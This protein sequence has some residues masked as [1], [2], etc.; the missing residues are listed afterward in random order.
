MKAEERKKAEELR[1]N[2]S[3]FN[4]IAAVV[5]VSKGTLTR[6][7]ADIHLTKEQ[8]N[9]LASSSIRC[10]Y[11]NRDRWDALKKEVRDFYEPPIHDPNFMLGL[12]L[13]WGEGDKAHARVGMSNSDAAV[14]IQFINWSKKY[15]EA[16][17][18]CIGVQHYDPAKDLIVKKWWASQLDVPLTSFYKSNFAVSRLSK[19]KR[20]AL[21]YGTAKIRVKGNDCWKIKVKIEKALNLLRS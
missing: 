3:S 1:R 9:K 6:W 19:N 12:G 11:K 15:F 8:Q 21:E 20:P 13:Y 17:D 5:G 16:K 14:L 2:G 10:G 4:E 18:F 7:L